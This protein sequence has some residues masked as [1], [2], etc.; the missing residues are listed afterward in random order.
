MSRVYI[1]D[2]WIFEETYTDQLMETEYESESAVSVRL[3]HTCREVPFHYF[4]ESLY[5]MV[6]GYRR[7]L[8]APEEWGGKSV[9]LVIEGAGHSAWVYLNGELLAEHHCGY[10]GFS[11][12][13]GERLRFGEDNILVVKV[14]SRENQNIPPFGYVVDYMTF[15]GL[16]RDV[17]L[18]VREK[19]HI[20]DVFART[21][22]D[23]DALADSGSATVPR[24]TLRCDVALSGP[25]PKTS[26]LR[27][28]L[29]PLGCV[30]MYAD[31]NAS[32]VSSDTEARPDPGSSTPAVSGDA[33]TLFLGET[34]ITETLHIEKTLSDISLWRTE[35]PFLYLLKTEL[36]CGDMIMDTQIQR[37]GFRRAEFRADGFYLNGEKV[38]LR[39]LNRHQSYPYVGYAMPK[40]MQAADADILKMELGCNAVRTSHYPQ[41]H[42]FVEECDSIGLLV[43]MELPGWQ[44]IGDSEWKEQAL[45]N[46]KEMITEFRNHTSVVLWGVR[47]NES[48]DDD[49]FYQKTN[50]MAH[51]LDDS[52]QTGGVRAQKKSHLFEDV[53]TYNDFLHDGRTPGCEPKKKVTPDMGKGYLISEYNGHMYPTKAYDWE[54]HRVE[55][56][57]RHATVLDAVAGHGDIAGSFGW[58][59]FDYNTHKD[60]GSGDRIC[61]HGVMDM[62]RN[63]KLAALVYAC[64]Q[65]TEPVLELSSSMDIGEHPGCNRGLTYIFTNAD[66]VKM[67]KNDTFIKEYHADDSPYRNLK[68][69]P[70]IIDDYIGDELEKKEHFSKKQADMLKEALNYVAIH[71]YHF[72][73]R[74]LWIL[75]KCVLLY[76]MRFGDAVKLYNNYIGDWGGSSTVYRFE[77]IKD[78]RI[79]KVMV[80]GPMT[81][82]HLKVKPSATTLTE[83]TG[84]DVAEVRISMVD[85]NDNQLFF[86]NDPLLLAT[87]GPIELIGP[88]VIPM[89]G[90]MTGAYVKT[91]GRSGKAALT[92][93]STTGQRET[94]EFMVYVREGLL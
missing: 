8:P 90:G 42:Y 6:C 70:I 40:S 32:T 68:H 52:R 30:G 59:M 12:E 14:D 43:F 77:A 27:Q 2:D 62:F 38:R 1:N 87:T 37:I 35:S 21:V 10:T 39:G 74:I 48:Q 75:A 15:G 91:I 76:H 46:L 84:Y 49:A 78:G 3:P 82:A 81:K 31:S 36:L 72:P 71:G 28:Y 65:E 89:Q 34:P 83:E 63:P 92:I 60:F 33:N 69:G 7:V 17:Y 45:L 64:E 13:L 47:I 20:A 66:S 80:K 51:H 67:Y 55:H 57:L 19:I 58:C 4:D 5:Q 29:T 25:A 44:H 85:E 79:Q 93:E 56:A 16:Y 53:Y 73:P 18:E 24:A 88:A 26:R 9:R 94:V 61:Y 50:E 41:S 11:A 54:E 22:I 86:Y 23:L